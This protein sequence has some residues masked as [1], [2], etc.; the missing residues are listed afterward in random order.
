MTFGDMTNF[1]VAALGLQDIDSYDESTMVSMWLNQG[2]ID[3]LSRTRVVVRCV[4]LTTTNGVDT[5]TLD[6]NILS[7]VD[8]DNSLPAG[9]RYRAARNENTCVDPAFRLIRA[10]VIQI[11]PVPDEDGMQVQVWAVLKPTAMSATDDDPAEEQFGAIPYEFHD[12]LVLYAMWKCG[13]YADDDS[14]Q[15][16]ERYRIL[17]EGQDGRGGRLGQIRMLVNKRGT[18]IPVRRR[19]RMQGTSYSGTYVGG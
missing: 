14:S 15:S 7:I 4:Q 12:A 8:S 19:V 5:Y 17:Y 3:L 2:V 16:G 18:S 13:D 9:R 6:Q 10:D 1:I 11:V